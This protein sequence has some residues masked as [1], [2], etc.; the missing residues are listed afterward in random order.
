MAGVIL[1]D[2]ETVRNLISQTSTQTGLSVV[3]RIVEKQYE[4]G[5]KTARSEIDLT[6][7]RP[8]PINPQLTYLV[9]A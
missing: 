7:I 4:K 2:Y 9:L 5:L 6:R 8:H 1:W 3:V